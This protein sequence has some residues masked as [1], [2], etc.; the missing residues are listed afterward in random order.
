[1]P[2]RPRAHPGIPARAAGGHAPGAPC[3]PATL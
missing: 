3:R 1:M 2:G